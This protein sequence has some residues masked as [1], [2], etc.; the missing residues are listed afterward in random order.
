MESIPYFS[1]SIKLIILSFLLISNVFLENL[2]K[3]IA[4]PDITFRS[5]E[6]LTR[7]SS[8][9]TDPDLK[10]VSQGSN[11][12]WFEDFDNL[13]DGINYHAGQASWDGEVSGITGHFEVKNHAYEANNLDKEAKWRS[14]VINIK[15][16]TNVGIQVD[17]SSSGD[18]ESNEDYIKVYYKLDGGSETLLNNGAQYGSFGGATATISGLTGSRLQIIIKVYND[19]SGE[20]IRFDN[21]TVSADA[22]SLPDNLVWHETFEGPPDFS[23]SGSQ[24]TR[25]IS[26]ASIGSLG[27]F[28]V[29][30]GRFL[31]RDLK[32][33]AQLISEPIDI[34]GYS[35]VDLS[36]DLSGFG[37]M[38]DLDYINAYYRLNG[39]DKVLIGGFNNTS[40]PVTV[41]AEDISG[42]TVQFIIKVNNSWEDEK[43]TI[44]NMLVVG[45]SAL[46]ITEITGG[47]LS[48]SNPDVTIGATANYSNVNYL[49]SGPNGFSST[50]Q[51]PTVSYPGTYT[52]TVTDPQSQSTNTASV[53]VSG[54]GAGTFWSEDFTHPDGTSSDGGSTA[55]S[56]ENS[57]GGDFEV[58]GNEFV[59]VNTG[60]GEVAKWTSGVIDIS[61]RPDVTIS[62]A[63]RSATNGGNGLE[64]S[65]DL[66]DYL[67]VYYIL[68]GGAKTLAHEFS[69][70]INGNSSDATTVSSGKLNGS[71]LQVIIKGRTT[72]TDELYYFD[73][74]ELAST[75][76]ATASASEYLSCTNTSVTLSGGSNTSNATFDWTGPGGFA[77]SQQSPV[78][79][80]P[81]TYAL[82]VTVPETGCTAVAEVELLE[83][84]TIAHWHENFTLS[85]GTNSDDGS[86]SWSIENSGGGDFEVSDNEF[87]IVNTGAGEIAKWTSE[88]I[89]ISDMPNVTIT[90]S[91]RSEVINGGN[92]LES[93]GDLDDY[94]KLYYIL[95]GGSKVLAHEFL[96]E[97]NG[98]KQSSIVTSGELN[99]STLQVVIKGRTTATDELYYFDNVMVSSPLTASAT[100][101]GNLHCDGSSVTISGNSSATEA[102]YSWTGPNGFSADTQIIT[103]S[104]PGDYTL[105]VS[106]SEGCTATAIATVE[107][108][109]SGT[110]WHEDFSLADHTN[111]DNGSTSWSVQNP[112]SGTFS[113]KGNEFKAS[114][115]SANEGIWM[116]E[117]IDISGINDVTISADLKSA[118]ASSNDYF[119]SEDYI[120]AYYKIDGGAEIL[121]FENNGGL[122][123]ANNST[124]TKS[125][126]SGPFNG[127]TVQ[128]I[129][130]VNNSHSTEKYYFD[131]I[132]VKGSGQSTVDA[133]A[134]VEGI[135]TCNNTSVD[136]T[137]GSSESDATYSWTGPDG[138]TTD[139]QLITVSTPGDYTLV[140]SSG[141]GCTGTA[142][143]TVTQNTSPPDV[144]ASVDG[145]LDC[146]SGSV[147]LL[148]SSTTL[149]VNYSWMG[150][151]NF[152]SNS[153][154]PTA[155]QA[156]LYTLTVTDPVNGC[157]ASQS[158]EVTAGSASAS[159][160]WVEDFS[161]PNGTTVDNGSTAWSI[162][163]PGTGTFSVKNNELKASFESAN[164][165]I[166][167]SEVIDI[168]GKTDVSIS[169]SLRSEVLGDFESDDYIRVSYVLDGGAET[170]FFEDHYGLDG[171]NTAAT[172]SAMAL[173]PTLNG[174]TL[175]VIIR[176]RNTWDDERYYIENVTLTG[177][178]VY[179]AVTP[180]VSVSGVLTCSNT[181]VDI[182]G[183][184]FEPDATYSWTGP[185]GFT[186]D[187]Q[188][189]TVSTPGDYTLVVLSAGG[190]TG[191][192]TATVTQN[193]NPPDVTASVDG[194]LD[195][196]SGSVTL[197]GSST[198][199]NAIYSWAG[200]D[201]FSSNSQNPTANEAGLYTLTVT[202]PA[203]ECTSSQTVTVT[204][205]N[206]GSGTVWLEDFNDLADGTTSDNGSTSWSIDDSGINTGYME[207]RSQRFVA[208]GSG[209][210]SELG[211]GVW[212]SEVIDISTFTD[213]VLSVDIEG[214]G[215]LDSGEDYIR[216]YY[217]LDGGSETLFID[218]D[219][220]GSF[221]SATVSSHMLNGSTVQ[222]VIRTKSTGD[223][224]FYYYDNI[225]VKGTG[226]SSLD[227]TATANGVLSCNN[228]SVS[229]TGESSE[230]DVTY[231][232]TGPNNF[233]ADTEVINVSVPGDYTL[234]VS[235]AGGCTG[236]ATATVIQ[237][238][239]L[240][241]GVTASNS[242]PLTCATTSVELTGSTTTTG[243][244]YR[245]LFSGTEIATTATT[246]VSAPG[247]YTL[248]VTKESTGCTTTTTTEV[249]I[250]ESQP[251]GV[252]ASNSGPLTCETTS[253]EL[254]G[255][256]TTTGVSYRWLSGSSEI[257]TTAT[258]TVS[259]PGTYTLEVTKESTGCT[260]TTTTEVGIDESQPEGV[261][262]SNNGPLT[263]ATTSVEL[264]GS[265]T[266]AGVSYRWLSDGS[267]IATTATTTV[268]SPG[269]YTLEVT[270]EGTGCT[271]TT[272]TEVEIDESQPEGV[273]ASNSGPLTCETTSV[274]LTGSTTTAGVSY[275][276]LSGSNEIA[277]TATTTVSAPGEYTLEVTKESTGCTTTTTTEVE[278][279][280]SQP[281]GVTASNSGPLTCATTSVELTGS[282]TTAGV[283]YRWLSDGSEIATTATTT[284]NS[285]GEYT[286]EVTKEST[287]CTTTTTTEVEIDE[288]QPEG[289]TASNSGPLTCAT[290]S[291][292]LTGSTTTTGVSYRWLS[293]GSE[294]ATTATTTVN[295]PGEYTLE[296]TKESTGCT[297]T[298]TTEVEIDESQPEGVTAS[299]SGPLTCET[300]SVELTG[301]TTTAGVSYRWLS[302][303]NEIATKATTTVNSPG[304]YT[305]EVTK[306]STGCTTTTTTEVEIDESQPE[307]VTA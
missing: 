287:G 111:S 15:Y 29:R 223:S 278:I 12:I 261:T 85:D 173:S 233:T 227:V 240:P 230:S 9:E 69:G 238:I 305:L 219:K 31:G 295:S 259:A 280:E 166:W 210:D 46:E 242:G 97:I 144:T 6:I 79:T 11:Q 191:T 231:S 160:F 62:M 234:V 303:S 115:D 302:G 134:T 220:D 142:T 282:T 26:G 190:C 248:E 49:W 78:V 33:E 132:A 130:R 67:R 266:T 105:V 93:S 205:G 72:A 232:W 267:E 229:I 188:V 185:N 249:E 199:P 48:C 263:C 301:S 18:L 186:A 47:T 253:V 40:A 50:S 225:T 174:S 272:T 131:N 24:W 82:T 87:V 36:V 214:E 124:S 5:S 208:H 96:G 179:E 204:D 89:D 141:G 51:Y 57:G 28:E 56:T 126:E 169:T 201:N 175:R 91:A 20:Y 193:T 157:T 8:P 148:G 252:T 27:Y 94:L 35:S 137:G 290:T 66:K 151:D 158:V 226:Q 37:R 221:T 86:T 243:V 2:N 14:E 285:P 184:S 77:S 88:V 104:A 65:G 99:G 90:M 167:L 207:V 107:P 16:H 200:P 212:T 264:T 52:V 1:R 25:D 53:E 23:T 256:T 222:L 114:F 135:L 284:V 138:F 176:L 55:W 277:T 112:G 304:E 164:E 251:E 116:S 106:T 211:R 255:S 22:M 189:I 187:T 194:A 38:E 217:K 236:T 306:E 244:S 213:V 156:G 100:V 254:T 183:G 59:V 237:N 258:T 273:T 139:T 30:Q 128:V 168:S 265:T 268:N 155:S 120:R 133:T 149:N 297:T 239:S 101:D 81:G 286:L 41:S 172:G 224:E 109:S 288:S 21:V 122:N 3:A 262:A 117:V 202:D 74:V 75:V 170:L 171:A 125:I 274:E 95:D 92:G 129:L 293:D 140:V 300:T 127:N 61:G 84:N 76:T 123:G 307:G 209:I 257:A 275:R 152:N 294:I 136:I 71:T 7:V 197:L 39:G 58:S 42:N 283:S 32:G 45:V 271:T 269:E 260:T 147:T 159:D 153:Q 177:T 83:F 163:N 68:D 102:T 4:A 228:T 245:W 192:A 73:N 113:V 296:V 150:P 181:S 198:T 119:E 250:D 195:C 34:S 247:E 203:N 145:V 60:A 98:N 291:V 13:S 10:K 279:D 70:E 206:S 118:T 289:V 162:Q 54:G 292:E 182:T 180:S 110:I 19:N 276:W 246:M 121:I 165:G 17:I 154:N 215:S 216:I 218:G 298:T 43:H 103:V 235:L 178:P 281:E 146:S 108:E 80:E 270:K 44:D 143:A 161:H 64:D 241:E 299:N 63:A 196:S